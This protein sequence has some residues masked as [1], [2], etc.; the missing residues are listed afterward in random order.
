MSQSFYDLARSRFPITFAAAHPHY[1]LVWNEDSGRHCS[2][3][4]T[5]A[6]T[7]IHLGHVWI[8]F[9][10]VS[11]KGWTASLSIGV[12]KWCQ[13]IRS[14]QTTID[15]HRTVGGKADIEYRNGTMFTTIAEYE[16]IAGQIMKRLLH[17]NAIFDAQYLH[18]ISSLLEKREESKYDRLHEYFNEMG[19]VA[20]ADA[21]NTYTYTTLEGYR[22]RADFYPR[23]W[24]PYGAEKLARIGA[25]PDHNIE[26]TLSVVPPVEITG[27]SHDGLR[28]TLTD[29]GDRM[30]TSK[31]DIADSLFF[32]RD[33]TWAALA[34]IS[35]NVS[36]GIAA[37]IHPP[38][39][40]DTAASDDTTGTTDSG[41]TSTTPATHPLVH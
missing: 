1:A 7:G 38:T 12:H 35:H 36:N 24:R 3:Y 15:R 18:S 4:L 28:W 9:N 31:L 22:V 14:N 41:D 40:T 16:R 2:F 37:A 25:Q 30:S 33:N 19:F 23:G 13:A 20:V 26:V 39:P 5:Q 29:Y 10:R 27:H 21:P 32:Q 8:D 6:V 34:E 11:D 17:T